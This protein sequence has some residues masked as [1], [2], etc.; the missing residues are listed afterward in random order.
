MQQAAQSE[1]WLWL[2]RVADVVGILG[3]TTL[4]VSY[5]RFARKILTRRVIQSRMLPIEPRFKG[6]ICAVSAPLP[7]PI[8]PSRRP[9]AIF[10]LISSHGNLDEQLLEGPIGPVLKA[11]QHHLGSLRHC[12]FLASEDSKVYLKPIQ[13]ACRKYFPGVRLHD[14]VILADVYRKIDD[15]YEAVH[16]VFDRCEKETD[17]DVLPADI[18]TDIT[19]GNK[20]ISIGT[21]MA[22]LD[23]DRSM[24]YIEQKQRKDLYM[25]D[26]TWEKIIRRPRKKN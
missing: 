13:E 9:E 19:G 11:I 1:W 23:A 21:A 14:P 22:C 24:Q 15:V 17:G 2:G 5:W 8:E 26:I 10:E 3:I 20:I 12:W 18:I 25:I 4:V 7:A 16:E 6:L